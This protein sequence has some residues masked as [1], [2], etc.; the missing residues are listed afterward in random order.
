M[1]FWLGLLTAVAAGLAY[2]LTPVFRGWFLRSGWVDRPDGGRKKHLVPIP[3]AGG[4]IIA[5]AYVG[6]YVVLEA[7]RSKSL[8]AFHLDFTVVLTVLPGAALVFI[9]GLLDD[10]KGLSP[11]MKL[12]A[13]VVA[14]VVAFM[15]GVHVT[16][17]QRFGTDWRLGLPMTL[18]WLLLCTNA[19][20]LIDGMD[21]LS[22][23]LGLFALL[24]LICYALLG[25]NLPLLLATVPLAGALAGFLPANL[26]PASVFLGDS[27]SYMIGFLVGCF[28]AV[29]SEKSATVLGLMAPLMA[30]AVPLA[31]VLLVVV[32]RFLRQKPLFHGDRLH[33]HHRLL[34]RGLTPRRV[35]WMLY[36]AA[37][38]GS[39]LALLS[40][41]LNDKFAVAAFVLFC[42]LVCA[43]IRSLG[44]LEFHTAGRIAFRGN[45]RQVLRAEMILQTTRTRLQSAETP[46]ACWQAV[47]TAAGEL[48]FCRAR[49]ELDDFEF[50]ETFD[51]SDSA[52]AWT[53]RIP[54]EGR[55]CVE[56]AHRF[57]Q[58][59]VALTVVPMTNLLHGCLRTESRHRSESVAEEIP[60]AAVALRKAVGA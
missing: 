25:N 13:Q 57:E 44:Y 34:E 15:G 14:C 33:I 18:F 53:I 49:M 36:A 39:L 3:R 60:E 4:V 35:V 41:I 55:G 40:T 38:V 37:G 54:I 22:G 52:N 2:L 58:D 50:S 59:V 43:G 20:N 9:I 17:L 1:M 6:S 29:W 7:L 21:G 32:R 45:F 12:S 51:D 10:T 47:K 28:S 16:V 46:A 31:D 42:G 27:G 48:G 24:T 30:F 26:N 19:F 23:G 56:L 8:A 11:W 5:L